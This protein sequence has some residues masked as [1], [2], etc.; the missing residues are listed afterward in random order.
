MISG[1][2]CQFIGGVCEDSELR[3]EPNVFFIYPSDPE[4]LASTIR[5]AVANNNN[6]SHLYEWKTWEDLNRGGQIVL[7]DIC[8]AIRN[9]KY[10]VANI[11]FLNFNVLFE[12]G[13][14]IGSSSPVVPIC[15]S[16][17]KKERRIFDEIGIFDT[18]KYETFHNSQELLGIVG[19][20][21]HPKALKMPKIATDRD[22]PIYYVKPPISLDSTIRLSSLLKKC[23]FRFRSFDPI[24]T[25]RLSLYDAQREVMSSTGLIAILLHKERD[26]ATVHNARVAF[27]AGMAIANGKHVLLL[28]EGNSRQ[29]I[30][31]RDIVRCFSA[32][33]T[34]PPL[35]EGFVKET[36]KTLYEQKSTSIP[37]PDGLLARIDLGDVAAENEILALRKY[38]V[39]TP[40]FQE[41]MQGHARLVVGRK[42]SGKTAIFYSV[43]DYIK[44]NSVL[45]LDLK[46]EGHQFTRLRETVLSQLS[47]GM[48]SHT[49]TAFWTYILLIELAR[50]LLEENERTGHG[51]RDDEAI[52][53][54][55]ALAKA[56]SGSANAVENNLFA[57]DFSERLMDVVERIVEG[58]PKD[59]SY[60][61]KG[62]AIT[63][64]IYRADIHYLHKLVAENLESWDEVWLLIDNL[65]K[66]WPTMGAKASDVEILK[67]LLEASR[68]L[69]RTLQKKQIEFRSVVF[70]RKDIHD[71]LVAHTPDRGKD[72]VANLDWSDAEMLK[73]LLLMRFHNADVKGNFEEVWPMLFDPHVEGESSFQYILARTFKRPRD[74]LNFVRKSVQVAVSR[75]HRRVEADDV[76]AAESDLPLYSV[77]T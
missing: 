32:T 5:E 65:D 11:T 72:P 34:L 70:I 77:P 44:S 8:Q 31:Y 60:A 56:Y 47:E 52:K 15:D 25:P 26:V 29:P 12:I 63:N 40:Q 61:T 57:R 55:E 64:L 21:P 37:Q 53:Q 10:V 68:N 45:V 3:A 75:G 16:T 27:L 54:Y 18:L 20:E 4:H 46:P 42:G 39:R 62:S 69:Q 6:N 22:Q 51:Y 59:S 7:C 2:F 19:R 50:K 23:F 74:L 67:S 24:E 28:Q 48:Q 38:F 13:F 9:T 66:G 76:L 58:F 17:Y 14:A 43:R 35:V 1:Q 36:A 49:L 33:E 73:T 30:D 41:T 71:L